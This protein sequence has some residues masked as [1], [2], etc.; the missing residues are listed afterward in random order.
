MP[1]VFQTLTT[2]TTIA[3]LII[4]GL[5]I[6]L[7][8]NTRRKRRNEYKMNARVVRDDTPVPDPHDRT[9]RELPNGGARVVGR[10]EPTFGEFFSEPHVTNAETDSSKPDMDDADDIDVDAED[11]PVTADEVFDVVDLSQ[12][13]LSTDPDAPIDS[14]TMDWLDEIESVPTSQPQSARLPRHGDTKI[15]SLNVIARTDQGFTGD[16]ILR[17]L[18]GCGLRFGDMDF[19]HLSE[20]QGVIP[21]IQFSVANMMQPGVFDLENIDELSTQGLMFFLTLPG[22]HDMARAFDLMLETA[23]IVAH[24]LGGDV[25][26][27]TR[28]VMTKQYVDSLRQSIREY[29]NKWRAE[30]SQ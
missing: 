9:S 12:T 13:K 30:T 15:Y 26:D 22:P 5:V 18:L 14:G 3:I 25:F 28:S 17:V 2:E 20:A 8:V 16:D 19:F 6:A 7:V 23:H 1:D 29:E 10:K 11:G 21:T 4:F 24:S 27:E